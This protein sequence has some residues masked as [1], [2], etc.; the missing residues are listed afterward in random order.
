MS[1]Y[2]HTMIRVYDL[3][4]SVAFYTKCLGMTELR[5]REVPDGK[6]TLVFVGYGANPDQ[7]EIELTHNWDQA[8]PYTVGNGFGHSRRRRAGLR[9]RLRGRPRRRRQGDA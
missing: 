7:A 1:R 5:R 9:R 8:E 2:L 3:E 6:Y 4:K